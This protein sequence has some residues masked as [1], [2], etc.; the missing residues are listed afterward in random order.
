MVD[1]PVRHLSVRVPWH[2]NH[3][4]GT[5][6]SH[7][8][9]NG[10]CLVLTNIQTKDADLEEGLAGKHLK[11]LDRNNL[12]PCF[13]EKATFM[14]PDQ[15]VRWVIHPYSSFHEDFS[16]YEYTPIKLPPF[17]FPA[18][19]FRWMMKDS[20]TKQSWTSKYW[21]LKYSAEKEPD[22]GFKNIW[23]QHHEN[24]RNLL[25]TFRSAIKRGKSLS[26]F[27]AKHV[28]HSDTIDR[29]LIGVG[30]VKYIDEIQEYNY[31]QKISGKR[32]YIWEHVIQHSIRGN[33]QNGFKGGFLLPYHELLELQR[34]GATLD[35]ESFVA[36]AP[37]REEFSYG[38]EHVINGIA[39]DALREIAGKLRKM[40][41]P[42]DLTFDSQY[43]WIDDRVSE[44][45]KMRGP[46]PGLGPVLTAFGLNEGNFIS[47]EIAEKI[48][49]E[50]KDPLAVDPWE[51]IEAM[52]DDPQRVLSEKLVKKVGKTI[53][54][55]WKQI[56]PN[57]KAY[58]KLLSR[59]EINNDQAKAFFDEDSRTEFGIEDYTT[60]KLLE[61][62]YLLYEAGRRTG[63]DISFGAVEKGV[64]PTPKIGELFPLPEPS[65]VDD[66]LDERRL[67]ALVI[68]ILEDAANEGHSLLP[69]YLV[70][71]RANEMELEPP[72][73]LK[74]HVLDAIDPFLA[75]KA[76][77]I[78]A[79]GDLPRF[80]QLKRLT[81]T[82]EVIR[83]F[84]V[85]MSSKGKQLKVNAN[86]RELLD[87]HP[88]LGKIDPGLPVHP[89]TKEEKAR[90][91]KAA[92]LEELANSRFSVLIGPAG[93]G[94]TTL[95]DVLCAHPD[96]AAGGN[97]QAGANRKGACQVRGFGKDFRAISFGTSKV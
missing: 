9:E 42:L 74:R 3:W 22:L 37:S 43:R 92:C 67:R 97:S 39:I 63:L 1:L 49:R 61:N 65:R 93:T 80:Y 38:T 6:C 82:G 40:E 26:F 21:D 84:L 59:F 54:K 46:F 91:E 58:I 75:E 33:W 44:L 4:N 78:E 85:G 57:R 56:K 5:V 11:D 18:V 94:K 36:K 89:K 60:E 8:R 83:K 73:N 41:G 79:T 69:D 17:S 47:L 27:Y 32:S 55:A 68:N 15:L 45:W 86:W 48:E 66:P 64:L 95:L 16:H 34:K 24:Q 87:K 71:Q 2:D 70:M 30:F 50:N 10:S 88:R 7:P 14:C 19:P 31:K 90:Q 13:S 35:L 77:V 12:P 72:P 23:V 62:A 52:F 53:C 20:E 28:P 81:E 96:I 29:V 25:D 51:L 76:T